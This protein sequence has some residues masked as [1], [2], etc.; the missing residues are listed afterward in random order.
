MYSAARK[1]LTFGIEIRIMPDRSPKPLTFPV[2]QT[3]L[4]ITHK[5][6][7]KDI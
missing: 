5:D 1:K 3:W 4:S 2:T 7:Q 6:M